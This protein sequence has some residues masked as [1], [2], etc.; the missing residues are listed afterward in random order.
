M[1]SFCVVG[2]YVDDIDKAVEFYCEMLGFKELQRYNNGCIVRLENDG[3]TVILEKVENPNMSTYPGYA[4]VILGI[5][6][7]DIEARAKELREKGVVFLQD[8]PQSF[9]AGL[10]MNMK[11][12]A[13]N[14]IDLLQFRES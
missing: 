2:I 1:A 9:V 8:G 13:G 10:Y 3:P 11:D 4:Q 5:E 14:V 7:D 6:T 12:P